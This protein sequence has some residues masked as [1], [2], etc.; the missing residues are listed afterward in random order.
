MR[1]IKAMG[2]KCVS[3]GYDR[4]DKAMDIHHID[5]ETKDFKFA[6]RRAHPT[7]FAGLKKELRK[8]ALVYKNCHIEIH[9]GMRL[10]PT[11]S[12]FDHDIFAKQVAEER[13]RAMNRFTSSGA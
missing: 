6:D 9:A 5:D 11:E 2:G 10:G 13:P 8:C 1:I 3:C 12:S 7:K 4:C